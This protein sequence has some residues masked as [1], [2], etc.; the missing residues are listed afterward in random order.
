MSYKTGS[1]KS[2]TEDYQ[3]QDSASYVSATEIADDLSKALL[4]KGYKLHPAQNGRHCCHDIYIKK[5]LDANHE[6]YNWHL[7]D[8]DLEWIGFNKAL[9]A[10]ISEQ[11][12]NGTDWLSIARKIQSSLTLQANDKRSIMY[13]IGFNKSTYADPQVSRSFTGKLAHKQI[14]NVSWFPQ[15]AGLDPY[16]LLALFPRPEATALLLMLGR[17]M[18]GVG[19]TVT[20][21]GIISHKMRSAAI[22]VGTEPALGKSTLLQGIISAASQLGYNSEPVATASS[23]FGWGKI[24]ASDLAYKDDLNRETQTAILKSETLKTIITGGAFSSERKGVDSETTKSNTTLLCCSNDYNVY[25]FYKMD[26]GSIS[27]FNFLYTY[28]QIELTALYPTFDARTDRNFARL[29]KLHVV[30][31]NQLYTYLLAHGVK[32]FLETLGLEVI[33]DA[34]IKVGEDFTQSAME[35]L[36]KQFI[37]APSVTHTRD[38]I[39]STA[40]LVAFAIGCARSSKARATLC[41][42]L[43]ELSFDSEL[44][45]C[46][47]NQYVHSAGDEPYRLRGLS[48]SCK[49][50]IS[51]RLEDLSN[52]S[53][54]RSNSQA[55]EFLTGELMSSQGASFPRSA[56]NYYRLWVDSKKIIPAQAELYAKMMRENDDGTMEIDFDALNTATRNNVTIIQ[57]MLK[58]D[59][60]A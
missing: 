17:A 50:V 15:L 36:R 42:Q 51:K 25:D 47:I 23:R 58:R 3:E 49:S 31:E 12:A 11:S 55:F 1:D 8:Q 27:R 5:R 39:S 43:A 22:I 7:L 24:A 18:V 40:H 54:H 32:L 48:S 6:I 52:R 37:Y 14:P 13:G 2:Q 56:G 26:E 53:G 44:L 33:N 19:G 10:S 35:S 16:E 57:D 20:Q 29:A 4:K 30:N 21:E 46:I 60:T 41:D 28:N 59:L 34:L 45:Y 9:E 38:L